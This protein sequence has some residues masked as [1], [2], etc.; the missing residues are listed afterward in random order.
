VSL[1]ITVFGRPAPQGSKRYVGG[2]RAQ[3][4]RFIEASKYLP[5]WR[6]AITTAAIAE[7]E[8]G[9]WAKSIEPIEIE[10]IFYLERPATVSVAKRPWPIKPPDLD[11]LLRGVLDGMTDA[12][13][14]DDDGQVVKITAWK[15]YADTREPGAFIKISPI[16]DTLGLG[17]A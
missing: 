5:A 8:N 15:V 6:K 9:S 16:F 11:K 12:G 10:V 7:I 2:N 17:L 3:G 13:V 14:W 4:G 1:T